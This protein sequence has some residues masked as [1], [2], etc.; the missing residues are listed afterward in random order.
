MKSIIDGKLYDTDKSEHICGLSLFHDVWRTNKGTLFMTY[1][2][3]GRISCV[4]QDKIKE[5]IAR[6]NPYIYIELF[7]QPE[8]A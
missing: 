4:D 2:L 6:H 3:E 7:G 5:L 1:N 8:E